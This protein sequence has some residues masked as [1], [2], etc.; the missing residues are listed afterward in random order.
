MSIV[1][2]CLILGLAFSIERIITLSLASVNT[3]IY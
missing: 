2:V 3:E 1:L